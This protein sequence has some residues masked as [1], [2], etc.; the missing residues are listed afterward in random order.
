[1][2]L[3][4]YLNLAKGGVKKHSTF[5][6]L[7][8]SNSGLSI[9]EK[10]SVLSICGG[11]LF[12]EI[13]FFLVVVQVCLPLVFAGGLSGVPAL[14]YGAK[15]DESKKA[16][17]NSFLIASLLLTFLLYVIFAPFQ[18]ITIA[19]STLVLCMLI[20]NILNSCL[21]G[22]GSLKSEA[23]SN[24]LMFSLIIIGVFVNQPKSLNELTLIYLVAYFGSLSFS[25]A[26]F[27][28][29]YPRKND[30]DSGNSE[31]SENNIVQFFISTLYQ[32]RLIVSHSAPLSPVALFNRLSSNLD[33]FIIKLIFSDEIGGLYRY[34][35]SLF[36]GVKQAQRPLQ[37]LAM[38]SIAEDGKGKIRIYRL[39]TLAV[40]IATILV[41]W[42][43][44][45]LT[46]LAKEFSDGWYWVIPAM[47]F[48]SFGSIFI[49][50]NGI[51]ASVLNLSSKNFI[52]LK[53]SA[54]SMAVSFVLGISLYFVIGIQA[55]GVI[56]AVRSGLLYIQNR[57][58]T[59]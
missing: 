54:S 56:L 9:V 41:V 8:F 42:S 13:Q 36:M 10:T 26:M 24:T 3:K 2:S 55:S 18:F 4:S 15:N 53:R 20:Q 49:G 32:I 46:P 30:G 33:F 12:G 1:M 11:A 23:G 51:E 35:N 5:F 6:L 27:Y 47:A 34:L 25:V 29:S 16:I 31:K 40:S 17:C 14:L 52:Y 22:L 43:M 38:R 21:K 19:Q 44:L 7:S 48:L 37:V 59:T 50:F 39:T 58:D 45:T 28:G 57:K